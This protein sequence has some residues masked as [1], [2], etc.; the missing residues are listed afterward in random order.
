MAHRM[1]IVP[2]LALAALIPAA[3]GLVG[4]ARAQGCG[5]AMP[6]FRAALDANTAEAVA[7]FIEEHPGCFTAPA[8]AKLAALSGVPEAVPDTEPE[9]E[10]VV[11]APSS[12]ET[13][14]DARSERWDEPLPFAATNRTEGPLTV[15]WIDY[16]GARVPYR[17][18]APGETF[19]SSSFATHP[20][21]FSDADGA[22]V[23]ILLPEAGAGTRDVG[24]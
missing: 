22:C 14:A 10:S 2:A 9:P 18:I 24:G 23:E 3:D 20:F 8:Q 12:C 15:S 13:Y 5:A 1:R 21:E 16:E 11:A 6:A 17:S 19:E 7:G 4:P